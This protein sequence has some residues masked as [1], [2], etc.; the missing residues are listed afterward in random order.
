MSKPRVAAIIPAYN[1]EATVASV[2]EVVRSSPHIDE[3]IVVSDGSQDHTADFAEMAG[4]RVLALPKRGGK[5]QAMLHGV[6]HTDAPI[7]F[8]C[9]ADLTSLGNDHI[10][11]VLLPVLSGSR[12]MNVGLH[13]RGILNPIVSRLPLIG[14]ERAMLRHV[15][16]GVPPE[17]LQGFMVET[18]LNYYCRSRK[19]PYGAVLLPGLQFRKKFQKVGWKRAAMQYVRMFAQVGQALLIV[20]LARLFKRF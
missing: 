7:L 4:A 3:V 9:D 14:G 1:E 12:V 17:F 8:F 6:A 16:E 18:A 10:E 13:D 19:L 5:G 20:R 2:V 11:R 15:I